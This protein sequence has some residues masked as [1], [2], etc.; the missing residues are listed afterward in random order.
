LVERFWGPAASQ[1]RFFHHTRV[2]VAGK[3]MILAR[4]GFS[5]QGGYELYYE[6]LNG[7]DELWD[8][9]MLAGADLDIKA[10]APSQAERVEG[11]L[12]SYL[13]DITSGM[14][15]F[16]AG[17]GH[18]CHLDKVPDC[19][20]LDAL[21]EKSEPKRQVRPITIDGD[22]LPPMTRFW[23]VTDVNG[24]EVGRISSTAR[25]FTFD[26]N[27]AIGLIDRSHWD[28]GT[29]LLVHTPVDVRSARIISEFPGR[30]LRK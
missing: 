3:P 10:G 11:G 27:I 17:L 24:A 8:T 5:L 28:A 6:G 9:L 4:S 26:I 14:T 16:E 2:D 19:L 29:E 20:A 13:S 23:K 25:A 30:K 21:R 1:I 12:L 15:P 7:G 18:F 22:L